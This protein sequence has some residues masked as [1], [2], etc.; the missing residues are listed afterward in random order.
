VI[1][2]LGSL[3]GK[4]IQFGYDRYVL[5]ELPLYQDMLQRHGTLFEP[6]DPQWLHY[7][8]SAELTCQAVQND[9]EGFGVLCCYTGMGM[10]IAANKFRGIYAARCVSVED[11][12]LAR[13]VNNANVLCLAAQAGVELNRM[14]IE[15]FVWTPYAG[16]KLDELECIT[17][18]ESDTPPATVFPARSARRFA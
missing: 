13:T 16:R 2:R 15:A 11:A 6:V 17:K 3:T 7:L 10:S 9:E 5:N 1:R 14:I 12:E 8:R 18:L 4:R